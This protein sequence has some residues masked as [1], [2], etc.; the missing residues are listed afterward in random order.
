MLC[1]AVVVVVVVV[2]VRLSM[3]LSTYLSICK[4]E[5]EAILQDFLNVLT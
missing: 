4:L 1:N 3:Y 2:A 5:N